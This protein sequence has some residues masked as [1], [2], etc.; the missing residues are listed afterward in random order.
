[1]KRRAFLIALGAVVLSSAAV[2]VQTIAKPEA[3]PAQRALFIGNSYTYYNNLPDILRVM[4]EADGRRL[5]VRMVAPGGWRLKDH[6]E[7]GEA[8]GQK[9]SPCTS[10]VKNLAVTTRSTTITGELAT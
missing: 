9:N 10:T 7:K 5:E 4:A 2:S 3:R 6:W 1:M 8:G